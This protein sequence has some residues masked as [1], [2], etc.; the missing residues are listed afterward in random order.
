MQKTKIS[1]VWH[2]DLYIMCCRH[3]ISAALIRSATR[4][5]MRSIFTSPA[6]TTTVPQHAALKVSL[7]CATSRHLSSSCTETRAYCFANM[8][9]TIRRIDAIKHISS[10]IRS[11]S[12]LA[13]D[14]PTRDRNM[15]SMIPCRTSSSSS[16]TTDLA[17]Q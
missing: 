5:M 14:E 7:S 15:A 12:G 2:A 16:V 8:P 1:F 17:I 4:G 9:P 3:L 11:P 6:D 10:A 13:N